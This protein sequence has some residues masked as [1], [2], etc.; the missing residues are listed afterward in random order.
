LSRIDDDLVAFRRNLQK[1]HNFV[2]TLR[3][4]CGNSHT[5]NICLSQV[6]RNFPGV[7]VTV[8]LT[9]TVAGARGTNIDQKKGTN[10]A[11]I[12]AKRRAIKRSVI[13]SFRQRSLAEPR[14][15]SSLA[16][17]RDA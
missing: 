7:V 8:N 6:K 14:Q 16:C 12:T 13:G 17:P 11:T 9:L 2:Q 15:H 4:F 3:R 10:G 5:E 1:L